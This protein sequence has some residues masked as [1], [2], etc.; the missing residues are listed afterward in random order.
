[1]K[2]LI[3]SFFLNSLPVFAEEQESPIWKAAYEKQAKIDEE[4]YGPA[5]KKMIEERTKLGFNPPTP[6]EYVKFLR[7]YKNYEVMKSLTKEPALVPSFGRYERNPDRYVW[8]NGWEV[9]FLN[10]AL[11][12]SDITQDVLR[13]DMKDVFLNCEYAPIKN[14][15]QEVD[16]SDSKKVFMAHQ[17]ILIRNMKKNC[18]AKNGDTLELTEACKKYVQSNNKE[19]QN[20]NKCDLVTDKY[21]L[22]NGQKYILDPS[23][24][25]SLSREM[26][27]IDSFVK[28]ATDTSTNLNNNGAAKAK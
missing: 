12:S 1:M 16:C 20:A 23:S 24:F 11:K 13:E 27:Q 9:I 10:K 19:A 3:I 17:Q 28:D 2:I 18:I 22:A 14:K 6:V 15:E 25:N 4:K 21:V 7:L 26:K 8:D 5:V